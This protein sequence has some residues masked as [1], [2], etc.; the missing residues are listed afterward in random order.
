MKTHFELGEC[1]VLLTGATG[2][3]GGALARQLDGRVRRLHLAGRSP[4]RLEAAAAALDGPTLTHGCD[5]G[6]HD[7]IDRLGQALQRTAGGLDTLIHCAGVNAFERFEDMDSE[8]IEQLLEVNLAAPIRLT[9]RLLPQLL[10][11]DRPTVVFVGSALGRLGYPGQAVYCASKAGLHRFAE[12]LRREYADRG[13]RV[14]HV[15]PRATATAFNSA[16]HQAVNR[17]LKVAE[18]TPDQVARHIVRAIQQQRIDSVIG[19]PEKLFAR[20]NQLVPRVVDRALRSHARA[21]ARHL[22]PSG[23]PAPSTEKSPCEPL[24]ES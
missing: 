13:L 10:E 19:F 6:R 8:R 5:L 22:A 20:I 17:E 18:D 11:Q 9:Q 1:E 7:D 21:V 24:I 16:E 4:D 3:I 2:G 12:A 15:A 14:V 23:T